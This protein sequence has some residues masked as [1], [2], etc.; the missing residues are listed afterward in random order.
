[1]DESKSWRAGGVDYDASTWE[2]RSF[3]PLMRPPP[4][5]LPLPHAIDEPMRN[6]AT[7]R[8]LTSDSLRLR[9]DVAG[10]AR[11]LHKLANQLTFDSQLLVVVEA[12]RSLAEAEQESCTWEQGWQGR[13]AGDCCFFSAEAACRQHEAE[14]AA[15][16]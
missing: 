4:G 12:P 10:E 11:V 1:M 14:L 16:D 7:V 15:P 8:V 5:H 3:G 2:G 13:T 9:H 6:S